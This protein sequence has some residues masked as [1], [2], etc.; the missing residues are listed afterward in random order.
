MDLELFEK[1]RKITEEQAELQPWTRSEGEKY[2][3]E[4]KPLLQKAGY[5]GVI[6]GSVAT[7]GFSDHD[8]DI[9]LTS[10]SDE[11]DFGVVED[12]IPM[13]GMDYVGEDA[14]HYTILSDGKSVDFHLAEEEGELE[15][16]EESTDEKDL[17]LFEK[18]RKITEDVALTP[19]VNLQ[20]ALK[21]FYKGKSTKLSLSTWPS[22]MEKHQYRFWLLTDGTIIPVDYA[23]RDTIRN[24][25]SVHFEVDPRNDFLE[26]GAIAG[27]VNDRS[28]EMDIQG[29]KKLTSRQI[30]QLKNI[31]IE[32]KASK[33]YMDVGKQEFSSNIDGSK[34]LDYLLNYGP[35]DESK[36]Q[37][38]KE[39][40]FV[41]RMNKH[42]EL[43]QGAA[44]KIV[45]A[46]PEFDRLLKQVEVHDQS[47]LEEPER[48][49]YVEITWRHKLENEKGE[50]D[51]YN[52][53]GYQT[54]GQLEKEEENDATMHHITSN[55]HHPEYHLEDKKDANVD[56]D[57]R[58]KSELVD[59]S[60][61]PEIDVAEMVADW[62]AMSE[63]LQTNTAREWFDKQKDKRWHFSDQQIELIDK[64][65]A[66]FEEETDR[67]VE[68]DESRLLTEGMEKG[69]RAVLKVYKDIERGL[70]PREDDLDE[71]I[72]LFL[73]YLKEMNASYRRDPDAMGY[74]ASSKK[75]AEEVKEKYFARERELETALK[76]SASAGEKLIALD[77][78][79]DLVHHDYYALEQFRWSKEA[80]DNPKF[81][82]LI[83]GI[84]R[85]LRKVGKF[86]QGVEGVDEPVFVVRRWGTGHHQEVVA[87]FPTEKEAVDFAKGAGKGY[88]FSKEPQKPV[89]ESKHRKA[90]KDWKSNTS[91]NIMDTMKFLKESREE[92]L[93]KLLKI[94]E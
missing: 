86:P 44:A 3:A 22:E 21:A 18:L 34:H 68:V 48:T 87:E 65:L 51:P 29:V 30:S 58:S 16:S 81:D 13:E 54:P 91:P 11:A 33:L 37:D 89:E 5:R 66:V 71:G 80:K 92:L 57:D 41:D 62:Q 82:S 78:V 28:G 50:Y 39:Q 74:W 17:D 25:T 64:L 88:F 32:Y 46:Y 40:F 73:E 52:G 15:E 36:E 35:M 75:H 49:P 8:L 77:N 12:E 42:I 85:L 24:A 7:E 83:S 26:T 31:A 27:S 59:A 47:K 67:D 9:H 20:K 14:P 53:K 45:D 79:V 84:V 19:T 43:V 60:L 2:L 76:S 70:D 4:I 93:D 61:M 1:L 10:V 94:E 56:M 90:A 55:S 69:L 72:S 6:I 23:H 38:E 63:E